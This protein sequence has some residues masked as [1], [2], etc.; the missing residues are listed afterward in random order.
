MEK[1]KH[2]SSHNFPPLVRVFVHP[3]SCILFPCT[4]NLMLYYKNIGQNVHLR[5]NQHF[6]LLLSLVLRKFLDFVYM[7]ICVRARGN[8]TKMVHSRDTMKF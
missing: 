5:E 8:D 4:P 7:Y 3:S 2:S 1:T 6:L